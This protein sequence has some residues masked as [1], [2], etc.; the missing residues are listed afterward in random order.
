VTATR[1][2][3]LHLRG[4]VDFFTEDGFRAEAEQLLAEEGLTAFVVD[5]AEVDVIDSSGLG[6]LIDLLRLCRELGIEMTLRGVSDR[7]Q[8]LIDITG[9]HEVLRAAD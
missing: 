3:V 5:L 1:T 2:A 9:L 4:D 8:Q 6:L 7:A